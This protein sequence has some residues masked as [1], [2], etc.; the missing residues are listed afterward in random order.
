[1]VTKISDASQTRLNSAL[2]SWQAWSAE[3]EERPKLERQLGGASNTTY[4]V[5]TTNASYVIRLNADKV[6]PGVNRDAERWVYAQASLV[7][8]TPKIIHWDDDFIVTLFVQGEQFDLEQHSKHLSEIAHHLTQLHRGPLPALSRLEPSV[9]L[10]RYLIQPEIER[11]KLLAACEKSAISSLPQNSNY[12]IC[13]NDLNPGN[14]LVTETGL[15]FLDWEYA[16]ITPVEF[17]IAVFSVTQ[18]FT[19]QQL[20]TF[21]AEYQNPVTREH[22]QSYQR[23]YRLIEILWWQIKTRDHKDMVL[24]LEQFLS[25]R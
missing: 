13:H 15:K 3:L 23:L 2:D 18:G 10:G 5:T 16:N 8:F 20:D 11:T 17:D 12:R 9:H 21:L 4:C 19:T 7:P 24:A 14:I 1:M 6:L 25:E 22:I